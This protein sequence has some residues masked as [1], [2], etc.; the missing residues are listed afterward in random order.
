MCPAATTAR[1][2]STAHSMETRGSR[3][4][5]VWGSLIET[6]RCC[7][8]FPRAGR[9]FTIAARC[10]VPGQTRQGNP[11]ALTFSGSVGC[12]GMRRNVPCFRG[13]SAGK[14]LL[15]SGREC[16]AIG[17]VHWA[18]SAV[19]QPRLQEILRSAWGGECGASFSGGDVISPG[20]QRE[21]LQ[22]LPS[23]VSATASNSAA[24]ATASHNSV[25]VRSRTSRA[26]RSVAGVQRTT[27]ATLASD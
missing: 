5:N 13:L 4:W 25:P 16:G 8:R 19:L 9:Q 22:R 18:G 24:S 21:R 6:L 7:A 15:P 2:W 1:C 11:A 14:R 20:A 3:R 12:H 17:V 27:C 10:T 26:R 23:S